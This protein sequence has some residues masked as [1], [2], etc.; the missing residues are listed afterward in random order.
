MKKIVTLSVA[1]V[2]IAFAAAACA[3]EETTGDKVDKALSGMK[4][5]ADDAADKA[6]EELDKH[7]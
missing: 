6:K 3:K 1:L 4:D 5:K 7:K 2:A